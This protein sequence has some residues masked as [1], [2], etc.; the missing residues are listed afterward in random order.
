MRVAII[1]GV[2]LALS[3]IAYVV[4]NERRTDDFDVPVESEKVH[5]GYM[6]CSNTIQ[7]VA[8][9]ALVGGRRLWPPDVRYN[10]G[11]VAN[12]YEG[13]GNEDDRW[14]NAFR[15]LFDEFPQTDTVWWELCIRKE[16][17]ETSYAHAEAV[18]DEIRKRIPGVTIYISALPPYTEGICKITG[19]EGLARAVELRDELVAKN[20][21]V[22]LG[23]SLG[24][25]TGENTSDDGCH[26]TEQGRLNLGIQMRNFFDKIK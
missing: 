5:I 16:E 18:L 14:W 17:S 26:L 4:F 24:P 9:Y 10:A 12:W 1:I 23:P 22:L 3:A 8:G 25:M 20:S 19:T 15:T 2:L 6:G 7:T 11:A 21:D 13:V